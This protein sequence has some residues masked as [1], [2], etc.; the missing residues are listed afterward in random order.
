MTIQA[1]FKCESTTLFEGGQKLVKFRVSYDKGKNS[2]FEKF[3]PSGQM[4][5][6]ICEG[7]KAYNFFEPGKKYLLNIEEYEK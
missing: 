3:T 4:E 1:L 2:D 6:S 5:M 7:T